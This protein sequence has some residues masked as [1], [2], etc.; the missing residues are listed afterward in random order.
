MIISIRGGH[1]KASPGANAIIDE[2]TEDRLIRAKVACLLSQQNTVI[3][4]EP[5][6]STPYPAEL[7][8]GIRVANINKVDLACSIHFN[9]AYNSY[10]GSIGAEVLVKK[11]CPVSLTKATAILK[12]MSKLGFVNRGVKYSEH[13]GELTSI[14][15]PSIIVEVCFCEATKDVALYRSLGVDRVAYAIAEGIDSRI[16]SID[17][18]PA[19]V[20]APR[21]SIHYIGH[22]QNKGWI[23]SVR[24]GVTCGTVGEGLRLEALSLSYFG[25]GVLKAKAH[26]QNY[27]WTSERLNGEVLGT[28]GMSLRLEA[29]TIDI[30]NSPANQKIKYRTHVQNIGWTEWVCNGQISGTIGKSLRIEAIEIK[31]V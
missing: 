11:N 14:N 5:N 26:I 9:K 22:V 30:D 2:L 27:G 3:N 15:S 13:L 7:S 1:T 29:I 25:Q 8:Y 31:I 23:D 17:S 6:E 12:N 4:S 16:M 21:S 24:D 20:E 19:V 18:L 10:E 28:I